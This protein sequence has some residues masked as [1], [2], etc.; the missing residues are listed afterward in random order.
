M[1]SAGSSCSAT[2]RVDSA[3]ADG[4]AGSGRLLHKYGGAAR[5]LSGCK[6]TRAAAEPLKTPV[7]LRVGLARAPR[8]AGCHDKQCCLIKAVEATGDRDFPLAG[9]YTEPFLCQRLCAA[10][11]NRGLRA[12]LIVSKQA[13]T[14]LLFSSYVVSWTHAAI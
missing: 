2:P 4:D 6:I 1:A 7:Q 3:H 13:V 8:R 11:C 9:L 14:H 12:C 5:K 10:S